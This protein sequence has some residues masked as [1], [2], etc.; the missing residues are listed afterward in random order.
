MNYGKMT[1]EQLLELLAQK[2]EEIS[3]Q[4]EIIDT[5]ETEI[6]SIN[7]KGSGWLIETPNPLY[8]ARTYGIQFF[9]GQAF[10][11]VGQSVPAFEIEPMK[12]S[13]LDRYSE[14]ERKEILER[15][16]VSP[17][18]RAAMAMKDEFGYTVT[19]FDGT[20]DADKQMEDIIN[21]R[22]KEYRQALAMAEARE[23]AVQATGVTN[24]IGGN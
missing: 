14:A 22:T 2:D 19:F 24:F 4:Q 18:E 12:K 11:S 15:M 10:I 7:A 9:M 17:A 3:G 20:E 16:S 1:K 8:D 21:G 13:Q 5:L 6:T 23:K